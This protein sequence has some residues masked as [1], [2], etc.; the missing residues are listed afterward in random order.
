[1]K[2]KHWKDD[3]SNLSCQYDCPKNTNKWCDII[4]KPKMR[5]L[6]NKKLINELER[7]RP[8]CKNCDVIVSDDKGCP[9]LWCIWREFGKDNFKRMK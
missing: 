5:Q 4:G 2:C 9:C 8:L 3:R 6:S 7:R 1:M